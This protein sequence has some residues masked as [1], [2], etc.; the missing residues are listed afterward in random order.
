MSVKRFHACRRSYV[1]GYVEKAWHLHIERK[2][3]TMND[4]LELPSLMVLTYGIRET[5]LLFT[6]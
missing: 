3:Q 6:G 1:L 4:Y 2:M 5:F